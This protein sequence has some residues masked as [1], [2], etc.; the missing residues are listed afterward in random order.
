MMI[1]NYMDKYEE[2]CKVP[3]LDADLKEE[4]AAIRGNDTEIKERF[5]NDL[6]FGTAGLR[7]IIGAGTNR[8]N[9]Y[10]VCRATQGIAEYIKAQGEEA[11]GVAIAYDCRHKSDFFAMES[12]KVLAAN[13]IKAYL[14]DEL[15]P[16]PELSFAIRYLGCAAGINITA[17][18]NPKEYNGYKAYGPDGGQ[19]ANAFA[20]TVIESIDS[21]GYFD[22]ILSMDEQE[23]KEKG[24]LQIIAQ[25]VDDAFLAQVFSQRINPDVVQEAKD[26]KIIYTPFH[27]AGNKSVRKILD[28]CGFTNV[29]VVKEQEQPDGDFPTVASPNPENKEGFEIAIRM[30]KEQGVDLIIG[31]DPDSD[32]VGVVVRNGDEY[33]VLTGNQTGALLGDYIL[34]QRRAKGTMP[35]D[36]FLVKTVVTSEMIRSIAKAYDVEVMETLTGF[37]YIAEKIKEFD[38]T[39]KKRY[40]FGFEESYGYLIGTYA[41]DK[42]AVVATMLIC[43]MAAYYH[44]KGMNLYEALQAL[45]RKYDYFA[46]S[47]KNIYRTGVDGVAEIQAMMEKVRSNI[48]TTIGT[49]PVLAYRDYSVDKR[50]DLVNGTE[51]PLGLP[52]SNVLYFELGNGTFAALRPSG[53]EPKFKLYFSA[54]GK[55]K[56]ESEDTLSM[57][58]QAFDE[59]F[60]E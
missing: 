52:K 37:K 60:G 40:V 39:D 43:E 28:M 12:A 41:R 8:M 35:H 44:T 36:P 18:H 51:A 6:E 54:H 57:M 48:P 11:K 38:D 50:V 55:T 15:R 56:E 20:D 22:G 10:T 17:S 31:T 58:Q 59:I 23:A 3:D 14:F 42:D 25:E 32:R 13:G 47:V 9:R 16:T 29:M 53:T 45:F 30:A 27:G 49:L 5:Q 21:I 19:I 26:L 1:M 46:E 4:L 24:L 2:W 7:G 33:E 34:S